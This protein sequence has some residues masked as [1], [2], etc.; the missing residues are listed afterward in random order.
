MAKSSA[1]SSPPSWLPGCFGDDMVS[2]VLML[3]A[4]PTLDADVARDAVEALGASPLMESRITGG[5]EEGEP[6]PNPPALVPRAPLPLP[7]PSG[8][9]KQ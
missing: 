3:G 4:N 5:G 6:N 7:I 1:G 8:T 2:F 9:G